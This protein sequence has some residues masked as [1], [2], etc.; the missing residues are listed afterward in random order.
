MR[1]LGNCS[2]GW[3]VRDS[4]VELLAFNCEYASFAIVLAHEHIVRVEPRA[5]TSRWEYDRGPWIHVQ[6]YWFSW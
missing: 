6:D 4:R 5:D 1:S 3:R 2:A